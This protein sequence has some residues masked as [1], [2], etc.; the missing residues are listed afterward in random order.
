MDLTLLNKQGSIRLPRL[1]G[2]APTGL[3]INAFVQA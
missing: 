3:R 1:I 2:G